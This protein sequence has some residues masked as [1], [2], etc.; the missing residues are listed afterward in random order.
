MILSNEGGKDSA[1]IVA[2]SREDA[3]EVAGIAK[4]A[5]GA[6]YLGAET[7]EALRLTGDA[8]AE[9]GRKWE[10]EHGP[11]KPSPAADVVGGE[12]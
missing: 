7:E 11:K 4:K 3:K 6:K 9:M 2:A 8:L 10:R 1:V 5:T 12:P